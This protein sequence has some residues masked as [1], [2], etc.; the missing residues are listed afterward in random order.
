MFFD[1]KVEDEEL[2]NAALDK[3]E[4]IKANVQESSS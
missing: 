3:A 2:K 1:V 4:E